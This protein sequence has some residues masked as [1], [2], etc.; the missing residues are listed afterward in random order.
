VSLDRRSFLVGSAAGG[1][2]L[3][4]QRTGK[5]SSIREIEHVVTAQPSRDGAGVSLRRSIGSG[6]LPWL[7]PFLLLDEIHSSDPADYTAGFPQHP[8]R[9]FETVSYVLKGGF[10]HRDSVGN[11]GLIHDGG[12]QWMTAGHGIVHEEMP[13]QTTGTELWGLQLWV[14]LPATRKMIRPRYQDL[15]PAQ[16]PELDVEEA[17]VR[18]VAGRLGST[19]GPVDGIDIQPTMLDANLAPRAAFRHDLP[20]GDTAFAYVLEGDV[21]FGQQGTHVAAGELAV[22]GTGTSIVAASE[23]GGR[24]LLVAGTPIREPVARRGPFVMNT[25]AEL[26]QAFADYQAGTLTL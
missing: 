8:H 26:R 3:A 19:R 7:D 5:S 18:L 21:M 15:S 11:H 10:Q 25:D 1:L 6:V 14:N 12:A 4:C 9:G 17:R 2:L 22:L 24:F 23:T 16:V 20:G 13:K